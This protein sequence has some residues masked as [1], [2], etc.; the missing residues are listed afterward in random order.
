MTLINIEHPLLLERCPLKFCLASVG[1]HRDAIMHVREAL[2]KGDHEYYFN[3]RSRTQG[4]F[5]S[6]WGEPFVGL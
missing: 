6:F 5:G 3:I 1:V 2:E 4:M